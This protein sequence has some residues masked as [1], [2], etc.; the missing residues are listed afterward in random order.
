VY[1]RDTSNKEGKLVNTTPRLSCWHLLAAGT[2]HNQPACRL[3]SV[4]LRLLTKSLMELTLPWC[5]CA[6]AVDSCAGCIAELEHTGGQPAQ[7]RPEGADGA[8]ED[9]LQPFSNHQQQGAL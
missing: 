1:E 3:R 2:F 4:D 9:K 5:R 7:A 6:G 8:A